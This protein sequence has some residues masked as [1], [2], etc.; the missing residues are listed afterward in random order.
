MNQ[1]AQHGEREVAAMADESEF[2]ELQTGA[3]SA[4]GVVDGHVFKQPGK[5]HFEIGVRV[6]GDGADYDS[7][8]SSQTVRA[9]DLKEALNLALA[10]PLRDWLAETDADE[11]G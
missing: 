1:E 6:R 10:I 11:P 8:L 7:A 3:G 9:W 2:R 5:H 4:C